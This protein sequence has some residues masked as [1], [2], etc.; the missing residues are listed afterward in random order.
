MISVIFSA[1]NETE[2]NYF[3]QSLSNVKA[4]SAGGMAIEAIVGVTPGTDDT[5]AKLEKNKIKT[6]LVE[7]SKRSIRYNRALTLS[8]STQTDWLVLHHPRSLLDLNAFAALSALPQ[9]HQWGAFTHQFDIQH[10]LLSFTSWWSN[11]VRGDLK[12]IYYLDHCVFVRRKIFEEVGGVPE[13]EIFEDTLLSQRLH[14]RFLPIRLPWTSTTSA[15]RFTK[16]GLWRQAMMN[17]MLK[18]QFLLGREHVKMNTFYENG[19]DLNCS[20]DKGRE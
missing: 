9:H 20:T 19:L 8:L 2:N 18:I 17:Q 11:Q 7:T 6:V 15:L 14:E 12:N 5:L 3:W 1:F 10:P 4:L 13:V 16:N